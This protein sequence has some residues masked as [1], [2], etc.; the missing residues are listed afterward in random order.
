MRTSERSKRRARKSSEAASMG[1]L[2]GVDPF[3]PALS[4]LERDGGLERA[5]EVKCCDDEEPK[6]HSAGFPGHVGLRKEL[7][8]SLPVFD[9]SLFVQLGLWWICHSVTVES[10][11]VGLV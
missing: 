1:Y 7:R 10:G 4:L 2:A 3:D 6:T 11:P 8:A 9:V 5:E